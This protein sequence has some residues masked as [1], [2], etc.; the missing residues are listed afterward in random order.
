M[1]PTDSR[2]SAWPILLACATLASCATLFAPGPD[3]ILVQSEPAGATVMLDGSPVGSTPMSFLVPRRAQGNLTLRLDGQPDVHRQL[4]TTLNGPVLV[5]VLFPGLLGILID[6]VGHN[7]SK[8]VSPE[9]IRFPTVSTAIPAAR[10]A[11]DSDAPHRAPQAV[12]ETTPP[13]PPTVPPTEPETATSTDQAA[14]A[15]EATPFA[16]HAGF[17]LTTDGFALWHGQSIE[18]LDEVVAR[19]SALALTLRK[20]RATT[21]ALPIATTTPD[22]GASVYFLDPNGNLAEGKVTEATRGTDSF[23]ILATARPRDIGT[24]IVDDCGNVVGVVRSA[25]A[26]AMEPSVEIDATGCAA[27]HRFL[28]SCPTVTRP[29]PAPSSSPLEAARLQSALED[30]SRR[31]AA[32]K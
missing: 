22:A 27:I 9:L 29:L 8:W 25:Q 4:S 5:N 7:C 26:Q 32:P 23:R 19:S 16:T 1:T 24:P 2:A 10:K 6:A 3:M 30:A 21:P 11:P 14:P 28:R 18:G 15:T 12:Q 31:S 20:S 17:H 13:N